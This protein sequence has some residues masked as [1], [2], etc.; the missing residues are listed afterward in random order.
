MK[1]HAPSHFIT[2]GTA[3]GA[4]CGSAMALIAGAVDGTIAAWSAHAGIGV[5][6]LGL[7]LYA[8]WGA[9]TGALLGLILSAFLQTIGMPEKSL[10]QRLRDD[11]KLDRSVSAALGAIC[12]AAAFEV[13]LVNLFSGS[14][15]A[16]MANRRLAALATGLVAGLGVLAALSLFFPLLQLLLPLARF[17]PRKG[18]WSASASTVVLVVLVAVSLAIVVLS[19][20]DWRV[21]RIGPWIYLGAILIGIK[22]ATFWLIKRG[23]MGRR[24]ALG[25][26]C[27]LVISLSIG[28]LVATVPWS[29]ASVTVAQQNG[30]LLPRLLA[31][32]RS[33]GD[34]DH[35]GFSHWLHG[36]D[37]DD[38]DP[39]VHPGAR[40][41]PGNGIDENCRGGDARP[42]T[43]ANKPQLRVPSPRSVD[44][45][46]LVCIDTVRADVLGSVGHQG[47]LTP[48]LD[49]FVRKAT[50][51]RRA[52]AQ[53]ANTPQSFP[54]VF[55]SRYP[56]RVPWV[57]RFT[58]YPAIKDQAIT[59]F[60]R[61]Q[62]AGLQTL[63]FSSHFYFSGKRGIRQGVDNWDNRDATNLRDSN[64][65]VASPRI[66][67][68]AIA[69]LRRLAATGKR[70]GMFVHL[71][72]PHS[73]Y[74]RHRQF[75][76]SKRGT[77]GLREKYDYEVKFADEWLGKLL[78]A[79]DETGLS[80]NTA[81]VLFS[82]HG[83]AFG[84]HR[85]YFHGQALYDEVL[86]VPVI[87]A[88]PGVAPRTSDDLVGLIDIGPTML[89]LVGVDIP[90]SFQ[91]VSLVPAINGH[92][93]AADRRLGAVLLPYPAWPKGQ[94]AMI[95]K[96]HKTIMRVTENRFEIYDLQ[97]DPR[98]QRNL[99]LED[100]AMAKRLRTAYE[101]FA[102]RELD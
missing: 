13:V 15:A 86:R 92:P 22:L 100:A 19:R 2:A 93:G 98:E 89:E 29:E 36:G 50:L 21:I 56:S 26:L 30:I 79:V 7:C 101:Q 72:E 18:R 88:V 4:L 95:T 24:V 17:L 84:E 33:F 47:G 75:N 41:I 46:L 48:N 10:L 85:F 53:A 68:R 1:Q 35:D 78:T 97:S 87:V 14:L 60:E 25:G 90:P 55:T 43:T 70:F 96:R 63:A 9:L 20:V 76:Y 73:T 27:G 82:D 81:V 74:V 23:R 65:D 39:Q 51:F 42:E 37:C 80:S 77:A 8:P 5:L 71:F 62:Q 52:Y 34:R 102:E 58:G 28:I 3:A 64:K 44:N 66:V 6:P 94:Q 59:V 32:A 69:A 12:L 54:S 91:G 83:E 49:R 61:L 40:D 31:M 45:V 67:P 99:A 38:R 16:A 57:R 11:E